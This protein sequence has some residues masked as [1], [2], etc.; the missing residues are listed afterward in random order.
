MTPTRRRALKVALF[1]LS[2][3]SLLASPFALRAAGVGASYVARILATGVLVSGRSESAM[4]REDLESFGWVSARVDGPARRVTA[5][6]GPVTRVASVV[7][8][9][10]AI[11]ESDSEVQPSAARASLTEL[12]PLAEPGEAPWP[13]GDE[14]DSGPLPAG[15]DAARLQAAV[16]AA[17]A[18]PDPGSP[19]RTRAVLVV[20]RGRVVAERY[21]PG[22]DA[23]MPLIGWSMTKSLVNA[24]CGRAVERGLISLDARPALSEWA[25][26]QDPRRAVSLDVL[27]R[28][29]SGLRFDESYGGAFSDC[30]RML[31]GEPSAAVFAAAMPLEVEVD[32]RWSYASG[33]TNIICLALAR[34]LGGP[35]RLVS[36]M[37]SELFEPLGMRSAFVEQDSSGLIV[38]SSF[39]YGCAR[40]WARLGLLYLNDGRVAGRR[41]LPEGWV[42]ASVQPTAAAPQGRYG[43]HF[44][45]NAGLD[46]RGLNRPMPRIPRGA[47]FMRGYQGQSVSVLPSRELVVVR[48]GQTPRSNAFDLEGL[49]AEVMASL[50]AVGEGATPG[51]R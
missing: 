31:F 49:L 32:T 11:I 36:F 39:G 37:R 46:E 24:L 43:R 3:L 19:L 27:L 25:G 23:T 9:R 28:M 21:A 51:E 34:A 35:E 26:A 20:Y 22:V 15:G 4:W 42:K 41:L 50:P 48:L 8:G 10:G 40:D 13:V 6:V 29:S 30:V 12:A 2:A 47:Y 16:S 7:A 5:S 17:F 18:E 38:G 33:S 44:W 14:G 1:I 45:L